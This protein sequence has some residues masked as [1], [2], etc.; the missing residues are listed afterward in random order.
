MTPANKLPIQ[1]MGHHCISKHIWAFSHS[2]KGKENPWIIYLE[3]A[4]RQNLKASFS[5]EH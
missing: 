4:E 2:S 5:L 3:C 1:Q